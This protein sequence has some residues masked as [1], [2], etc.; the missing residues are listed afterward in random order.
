MQEV[1]YKKILI[2]RVDW[3]PNAEYRD[4]VRV[5]LTSKKEPSE[6]KP[7]KVNNHKVN[8]HQINNKFRLVLTIKR[9]R[10]LKQLLRQA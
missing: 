3:F 6:K 5:S 1:I 2:N 9:D 10:K 8:K 4:I 7:H